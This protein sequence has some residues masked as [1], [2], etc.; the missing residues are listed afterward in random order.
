[1]IGHPVPR[2]SFKLC[3]ESCNRV[4]SN[5]LVRLECQQ[6]SPF[7]RQ[8]LMRPVHETNVTTDTMVSWLLVCLSVISI[9][10]GTLCPPTVV[11]NEC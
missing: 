2:E 3:L 8:W 11:S 7:I 5:M 4:L 6:C 1:M 10:I 9:I